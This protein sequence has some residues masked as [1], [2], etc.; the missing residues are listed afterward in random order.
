MLTGAIGYYGSD[1]LFRA[2]FALY[3]T[4]PN[5]PED[6][7]YMAGQVDGEGRP[8]SGANRYVLTFAE[9]QTP[10]VNAFWSVVLYDQDG[11]RAPNRLNR[12]G[13]GD[14]DELNF[15]ADGS[16]TIYIQRE[17]PGTDQES[18]WLPAPEGS[19]NLIMR[20]YSPGPEVATGEWV[21][22]PM[23]KVGQPQKIDQVARAAGS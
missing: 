15:N 7:I 18:N 14:Q 2:A 22:P 11:F 16:L 5:R 8:L 17:S 6:V 19:F 20:A 13:I 23:T 12:F 21:P 9:G 1:Y 4:G 10:P 3:G